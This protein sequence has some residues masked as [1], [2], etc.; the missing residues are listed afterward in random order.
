LPKKKKLKTTAV[1]QELVEKDTPIH[2]S[3]DGVSC[4]SSALK[5]HE[6]MKK[7]E[8]GGG[9]GG[10][11]S[12]NPTLQQGQQQSDQVRKLFICYKHD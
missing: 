4:S 9:G 1:T 10:G 12:P 6:E 3:S 11:P 5:R 8:S 2:S 7:D